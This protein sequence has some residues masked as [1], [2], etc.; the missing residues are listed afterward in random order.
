MN[1]TLEEEN[2]QNEITKKWLKDHPYDPAS[3][4]PKGWELRFGLR[5]RFLKYESVEHAERKNMITIRESGMKV[6]F[7]YCNREWEELKSNL[8]TDDEVWLHGGDGGT[9]IYLIRNGQIVEDACGK[10][11]VPR[12]G[13]HIILKSV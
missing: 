9:T 12:R 3:D 7:G 8:Q 2:K 5:G 6:P 11:K 4:L 13:Y 1:C 10:Y